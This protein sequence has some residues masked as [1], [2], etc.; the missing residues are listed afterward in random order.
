MQFDFPQ[1]C[2]LTYVLLIRFAGFVSRHANG[3][4][5]QG[6]LTDHDLPSGERLVE[7]AYSEAGQRLEAGRLRPTVRL[8][9]V[10][11]CAFL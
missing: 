6:R 5:I 4:K 10:D 1:D 7:I 11:R 8:E 3:L 2:I 9:Y